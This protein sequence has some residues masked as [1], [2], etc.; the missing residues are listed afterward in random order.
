M[1]AIRT[2]INM[3]ISWLILLGSGIMIMRIST[4]SVSIVVL[5]SLFT[6][7]TVYILNAF[8]NKIK[9]F[10]L[11][12]EK[13]RKLLLLSFLIM[14]VYYGIHFVVFDHVDEYSVFANI[15][16]SVDFL[17]LVCYFTMLII[18]FILN[19][20]LKKCKAKF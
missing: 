4:G 11:P 15:A 18:S 5:P 2:I 3:I 19:I 6:I 20:V 8:L 7:I 10:K 14:S 17:F 16:Q 13:Y 12:L 9:F 1:A